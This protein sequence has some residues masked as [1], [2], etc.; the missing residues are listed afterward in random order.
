MFNIEISFWESLTLCSIKSSLRCLFWDLIILILM[1]LFLAARDK[2]RLQFRPQLI[3]H[4]AGSKASV[5]AD[6]DFRDSNVK[7][8]GPGFFHISSLTVSA[9]HSHDRNDAVPNVMS[10]YYNVVM[11]SR[12]HYSMTQFLIS[13]ALTT[14]WNTWQEEMVSIH[15]LPRTLPQSFC[16]RLPVMIINQDELLVSNTRSTEKKME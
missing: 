3:S 10:P 9:L 5:G 12:G 14:T 7:F 15:L 16:R 1:R 13:W 11:I 4:K 6:W 8:K 2:N